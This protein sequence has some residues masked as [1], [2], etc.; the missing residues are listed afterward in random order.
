VCRARD[1]GVDRF[2]G[3]PVDPYE[4]VEL[5]SPLLIERIEPAEAAPPA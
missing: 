4:R 5:F 2:A 3:E 1:R